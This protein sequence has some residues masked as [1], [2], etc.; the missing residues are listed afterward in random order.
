MMQDGFFRNLSLE[1]A[2]AFRSWARENHKPGESVRDFWHPVVRDECA[3]IDAEGEVQ[4]AR[5]A[6]TS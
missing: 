6:A 1:E 4:C 5:S 3:K 2:D